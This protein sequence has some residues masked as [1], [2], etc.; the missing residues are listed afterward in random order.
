M[1]EIHRTK[2]WSKK[3]ACSRCRYDHS[4]V[5]RGIV[6]TL[7][8][9][10]NR[11]QRFSAR[12]F[13]LT[14][15]ATRAHDDSGIAV[16]GEAA[17][18]I[19]IYGPYRRLMPGRYRVSHLIDVVTLAAPAA[20]IEPAIEI[21]IVVDGARQTAVKKYPVAGCGPIELELEFQSDGSVTEFRVGKTG[22]EFVHKGALVNQLL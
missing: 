2:S 4:G 18:G 17:D 1:F 19:V 8:A 5:V 3:P 10:D 7:L 12:A 11:S 9:P 6:D 16:G 14:P 20:S 21:D 13:H 15:G 22:V